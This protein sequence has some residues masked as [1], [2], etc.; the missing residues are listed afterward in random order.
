MRPKIE[1]WRFIS[2]LNQVVE[3]SDDILLKHL[4]LSPVST[5]S[6]RSM[7]ARTPI[8]GTTSG[9]GHYAVTHVLARKTTEYA[10]WACCAFASMAEVAWR[11]HSCSAR[12][13]QENL[14]CSW[15]A[16]SKEPST[17]NCTLT[18]LFVVCSPRTSSVHAVWQDTPD[19]ILR[20][21][22]KSAEL[23]LSE[24]G[25]ET[26]RDALKLIAKEI[27]CRRNHMALSE[28]TGPLH[29]FVRTSCCKGNS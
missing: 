21:S 2:F 16:V 13:T 1:S 10:P 18:A 5:V 29:S 11:N 17:N 7:A 26:R 19:T 22:F 25:N 23:E 15:K 6:P 8:A 14:S 12:N 28:K 9:Y 27:R 24:E 3:T 4:P 20:L